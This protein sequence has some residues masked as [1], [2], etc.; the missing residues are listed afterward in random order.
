[1]DIK[2]LNESSILKINSNN[3]LQS[4]LN[5]IKEL[6]DNS[7]DAEASKI[8]IELYDSATT[9]IIC[10]DNGK[11]INKNILESIGRRGSTTKLNDIEDIFT[12][13]THG[14]RGQAISAIANLCELSLLTKTK[15][16]EYLYRIKFSEEGKISNFEELN[17]SFKGD[18]KNFSSYESGCV[19][20]IDNLFKHNPIRRDSIIKKKD[21]YL[22]EIFSL[23]QSYALINS[24][25]DFEVFHKQMNLM[26][27]IFSF[28]K[29]VKSK[30][31]IKKI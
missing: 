18:F 1:M 7:I 6:V 10:I 3:S 23:L 2:K 29:I 28:P 17:K 4:N 30:K 25:I 11:G 22:N 21:F 8:H 9:K 20:I 5:I 24:N 27:K 19:F 14:F 26:K 16:G 31:K 12:I 15:N 13:K